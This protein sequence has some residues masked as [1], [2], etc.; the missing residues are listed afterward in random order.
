MEK[1]YK[2]TSEKIKTNE[3]SSYNIIIIVGFQKTKYSIG[4][5]KAACKESDVLVARN[6]QHD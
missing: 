2:Y 6:K 5:A 3:N 1:N 4:L